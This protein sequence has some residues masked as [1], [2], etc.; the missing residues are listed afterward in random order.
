MTAHDWGSLGDDAAAGR[1][2]ESAL[3]AVA[4][5]VQY[6]DARLIECEELRSYVQKGA[7]PDER[8]PGCRAIFW[9]GTATMTSIKF[10]S[11]VSLPGSTAAAR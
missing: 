3:D 11:T 4:G 10:W 8:M 5:R 9:S 1:I 7:D 6:A 2:L